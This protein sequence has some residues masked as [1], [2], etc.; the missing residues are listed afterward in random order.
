MSLHVT[1]L[2]K[3]ACTHA[4]TR[5]RTHTLKTR[6]ISVRAVECTAAT[7]LIRCLYK[8][9]PSEKKKQE[10]HLGSLC[11]SSQTHVKL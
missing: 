9:L 4:H 7:F 11:C 5:M 8:M 1:K 2:L 6:K 10:E 3:N